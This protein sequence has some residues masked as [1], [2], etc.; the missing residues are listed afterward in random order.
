MI[1]KTLDTIFNEYGS[2]NYQAS[3]FQ[4]KSDT[5][6]SETSFKNDIDFLSK[7]FFSKS[8]FKN[9]FNL[10]FKNANHDSKNSS[11]Y[12]GELSSDFYTSL[13]LNSSL[14]LKNSSTNFEGEFTPKLSLR[15]S[16][17]RSESIID[18][19]R[20]INIV[21]VFSKN[22]LGLT[23]SLEGGQSLTVGTDY[24]L[25][26]KDGTEFLEIGLAQ[27]YR[28]I[29]EERLPT[30]SKMNTKS[31]DVV[32]G[33]KFIPNNYINFDYDFS[34]DNNLKTSNYNMAKSTISINN[35]ITSFEFLEE[36]NEIGSDSYLSNETSY[37]FNNSNKLLFRQRTNRKTDMK[38]FY[39]LIYQY[40]NDCLV[41]AI[42]YNKDYYSDRDLKPTE[43]LFLSITIVP[44]ASIGS[45]KIS[46]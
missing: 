42:E 4:K 27:I 45:P 24:N 25:T 12:K 37:S 6:I 19:D 46:K 22:R 5:N 2:F 30:K 16:P 18:E 31:S 7:P 1:S 29:N 34:L 11:T 44:F 32:G 28:D 38:E 33:I 41:A 40:E 14:P 21:N 17:R 10:L 23:D 9:N 39:N 15:A 13:I 36:H 35:F 26:K 3:G 8:G 43:E 20:R